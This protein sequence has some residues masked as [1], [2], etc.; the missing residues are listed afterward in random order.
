MRH[1]FYE[2]FQLGYNATD[3]LKWYVPIDD[4]EQYAAY[5]ANNSNNMS[6]LNDNFICNCSHPSIF[7]RYCEYQLYQGE[8]ISEA[9]ERQFRHRQTNMFGS[10]MHE[11]RSCYTTL[12]TCDSGL[13]CLDWRQICDGEQNCIYGIDEDN[14]DKLEFNECEENEYRCANGMCIPGEYFLDGK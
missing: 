13:L 11:R 9:I 12:D 14:C 5:Q 7:G 8:T 2:L 4:V 3:L 10:Q 1:T 6:N